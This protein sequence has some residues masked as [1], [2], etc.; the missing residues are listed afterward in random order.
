VSARDIVTS[1]I[2]DAVADFIRRVCECER[3]R[4]TLV[5]DLELARVADEVVRA[6]SEGREGV[7]GP[8][9]MRAQKKPLRRRI[10]VWLFGREVS[11]EELLV[12]ISKARSRAA[13]LNS[14]CSQNALLETIY[15]T[16]D[17]YL[18]EIIKRDFEKFKAACRGE[19]PSIDFN[20]V[21]SY[22]SE[23]I[24]RGIEVYLAAHGASR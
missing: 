15:K 17:R 10:R 14:D 20:E 5:E 4:E 3:S 18:I 11:V 22:V 1:I 24:R 21:P 19:A 16:E 9:I 12:R 6:V 8:V 23:G 2:A 13:W 7:F